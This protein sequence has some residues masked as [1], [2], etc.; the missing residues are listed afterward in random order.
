M[1]F[2]QAA[3]SG[4][5][6]SEQ[7]AEFVPSG[8]VE[9]QTGHLS[10]S[11]DQTLGI[12]DQRRVDRIKEAVDQAFAMPPSD[13][14]QELPRPEHSEPDIDAIDAIDARPKALRALI[15]E[16]N[17]PASEQEARYLNR[18]AEEVADTMVFEEAETAAA[19]AT[20]AA[21]SFALVADGGAG[22]CRVQ[23]GDTLWKIAHARLGDGHAWI[24]IYA[25]NRDQLP[26]AYELDVGQVLA[27][28]DR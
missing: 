3:N 20:A 11:A 2:A 25:A 23:P 12:G 13:E 6:V 26:N 18:L 7:A 14:P 16:P 24:R 9:V 4:Q 28:P 21:A 27:L 1:V 19:A 17:Q 8:V 10:Q 5:E 22:A 15:L